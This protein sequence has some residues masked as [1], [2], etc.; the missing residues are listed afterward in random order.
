[1]CLSN[2]L[3]ERGAGSKMGTFLGSLGILLFQLVSTLRQ[4]LPEAVG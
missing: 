1:M 4:K 2:G 3:N